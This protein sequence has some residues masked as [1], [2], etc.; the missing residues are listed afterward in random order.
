MGSTVEVEDT[1]STRPNPRSRMPGSD[2]LDQ[3]ERREHV[4]AVGRL[5]HLALVGERVGVDRRAARVDHEDVERAERLLDGVDQ[6]G[7]VV[8]VAGVVDDADS[9]D[10][11]GR[12]VDALARPRADGHARRPRR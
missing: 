1:L 7:R 12:G 2:P 6:G 10:G 11:L 5:P 3:R 8:E 9:A 4:L